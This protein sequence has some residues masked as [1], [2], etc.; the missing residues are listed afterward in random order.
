MDLFGETQFLKD[1]PGM[2]ILPSK[3][4]GLILNG[5]FSFFANWGNGPEI[6]DSYNLKILISERFPKEL[7][8]V[9]EIG[10]K[11]P[12]NLNHHVANDNFLC[13][14]SPLRLLEKMNKNPTITGFTEY[15]LV[16]YL[17]AISY[18]LKNGKFPFGELAHGGQ[19]I[20]DDYLDIFGLKTYDQVV[21]TLILLG[22][23]KQRANKEPC[24][25]GCGKRLG[26]CSFHNKLND[27]RKMAETSWFKNQIAIVYNHLKEM[28]LMSRLRNVKTKR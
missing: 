18:K 7:P 11:I 3:N 20:I 14:G 16:P 12:R 8:K 9:E 4:K 17:Y 6:E 2:S 19:G 5:V 22:M 21:N 10:Q 23:K 13:L 15:C 27:Y 24:P 1:Q 26:I 28:W 25:C